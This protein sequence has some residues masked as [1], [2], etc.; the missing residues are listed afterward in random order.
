[1]DVKIFRLISGEE[2]LAN[3]TDVGDAY[4]F[5][6]PMVIIP[7]DGGNIGFA[8]FMPYTKVP[9]EGVTI[10]KSYIAYSVNVLEDM[11]EQYESLFDT[12]PALIMPDKKIITG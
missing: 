3:Y 7:Q 9:D 11:L 5:E 8:Y 6:K 4:L 2:L 10:P 1:M 12:G